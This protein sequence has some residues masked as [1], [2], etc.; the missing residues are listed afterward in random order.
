MNSEISRIRQ[1]FKNNWSGRTW[2]GGNLQQ[3]FEGIDHQIAFRK[4]LAGSH[5]IYELTVHM[6]CWRTFVLENLK[7]NNAYK[8]EL[9][10]ETDWPTK[11]QPTETVWKQAL[12]DFEKNQAETEAV[13]LNFEES[14]LDELVP[15]R[16][17]SWYTLLHGIIEHDI[18][19]SAQISILKKPV[20]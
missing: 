3:I 8:V 7:G 10:S 5:N 12:S 4:P 6:L 16:K 9:N 14:R 20:Q 11:Y 13:L 19:H 15:E 17:F 1:Q 2:H 18:Y